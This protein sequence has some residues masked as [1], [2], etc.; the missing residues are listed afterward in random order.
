VRSGRPRP[1]HDYKEE[2]KQKSRR[3][4]R[5][6]FYRWIMGIIWFLEARIRCRL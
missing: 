4:V 6:P 1:E 2:R 3:L 5:R